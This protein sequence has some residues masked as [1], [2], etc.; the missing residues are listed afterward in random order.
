MLNRMFEQGDSATPALDPASNS[1]K[2]YPLGLILVPTR[3]LATKIFEE[4]KKFCYR[5]RMRPAVLY[6][7][8]NPKEQ[9]RELEK[10][11]HL[12]VATPGRLVDVINRGKIGLENLRFL[13]FNEADRKLLSAC[14][15]TTIC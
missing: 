8:N 4:A 1:S 15:F 9:I 6:G 11:C 2:Q 10:G 3:D 7:G 5:S 13:V 14:I 12:I